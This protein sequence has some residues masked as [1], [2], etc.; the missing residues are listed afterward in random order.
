M[1]STVN[2]SACPS[3][4]RCAGRG[5][6]ARGRGRRA[7]P[8]RCGGGDRLQVRCRQAAIAGEHHCRRID[9]RLA[10]RLLELD[11]PRGR[12]GGRQVGRGGAVGHAGQSAGQRVEEDEDEYPG[13]QH[14]PAEPAQH[15]SEPGTRGRSP[16]PPGQRVA[17]TSELSL[18]V[19]FLAHQ[20]RRGGCAAMAGSWWPA[21]P[22][23]GAGS[24]DGRCARAVMLMGSA[25]RP[26]ARH[27][28]GR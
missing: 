22:A 16:R 27:H 5:R 20:A 12:R 6:R 3:A 15:P 26:G 23:T 10:R 21:A 14:R 13:D 8:R 17:W 1:T 11:D 19:G 4:D 28:I 9:V 25:S 18:R 2:P 7:V 24:A